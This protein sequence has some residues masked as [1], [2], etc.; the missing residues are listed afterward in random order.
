M[1]YQH[2]TECNFKHWSQPLFCLEEQMFMQ[3]RFNISLKEEKM[4]TQ[5]DDS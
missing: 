1:T 2:F 3:E 5:M 4:N